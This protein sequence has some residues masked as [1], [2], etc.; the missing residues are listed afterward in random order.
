MIDVKRTSTFL[1]ANLGSEIAR[2]FLAVEKGDE[3][4]IK[5]TKERADGILHQLENMPDMK[6]RQIELSIINEVI[7]DLEKKQKQFSV[8]AESFSRYFQP[9]ALRVLSV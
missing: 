4:K 7:D 2:L 8:T 5:A 1:M 9:F 6:S 3:L